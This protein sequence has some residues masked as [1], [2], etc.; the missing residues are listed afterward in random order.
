MLYAIYL[1]DEINLLETTHMREYVRFCHV[2]LI[3]ND[4]FQFYISLFLHLFLMFVI[5]YIS[6]WEDQRKTRPSLG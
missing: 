1:E 2:N 4:N 5:I 3:N 6:A